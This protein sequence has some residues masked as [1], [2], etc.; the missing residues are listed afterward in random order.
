MKRFALAALLA[1]YA[2][3]TVPAKDITI[4]LAEP[5]QQSW[6]ALGRVMEQ[7]ISAA[8]MRAD[9]ALCRDVYAFLNSFALKVQAAQQAAAQTS[10][11]V[12]SEKKE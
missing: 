10:A 9:A 4:T 7:C 12:D 3:T 11:P 5:E 1:L 6:A 8:T 2:A